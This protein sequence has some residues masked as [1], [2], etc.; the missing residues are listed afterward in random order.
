MISKTAV[1]L[2]LLC[3]VTLGCARSVVRG[4][5][6]GVVAIPANTDIWPM[7]FRTKAERIMREHF[8]EGY[9][10][11]HE[12][13]TVVGQT[14]DTET[15]GVSAPVLRKGPFEINLGASQTTETISDETEWRIYYRR[16]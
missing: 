13:E 10:I 4:P 8:P 2:V 6:Y 5:D 7:R 16:G 1:L 12:E 11:E 14:V 9:V 15:E 3:L